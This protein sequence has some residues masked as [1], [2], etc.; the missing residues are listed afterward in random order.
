MNFWM[1]EELHAKIKEY[2]DKSGISVAGAIAVLC[3]YAM[4]T[5]ATIRMSTELMQNPQFLEYMKRAAI[6]EKD[7]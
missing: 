4:D 5:M 6:E 3:S 7:K 1:D 2:A